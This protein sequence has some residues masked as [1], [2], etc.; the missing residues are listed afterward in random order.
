MVNSRRKGHDAELK[1][2]AMMKRIT[3]HNFIQTPGSGSG[4]IKG[5]L[6]VEHKHNLFCIEIKHYKDMAFN[7]K[8]FTQ[9]SNVFVKWWSK[10]CKQAEQMNQEP[11]LI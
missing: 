2:A 10:L 1:A 7:H 5:D 3:G 4:K 11:L 8:I 6:Y 9:K